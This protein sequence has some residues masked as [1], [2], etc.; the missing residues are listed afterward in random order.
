[1]PIEHAIRLGA[2]TLSDLEE[3][4]GLQNAMG[5]F[6]WFYLGSEFCE[7]LLDETLCGDIANLQKKGKKVCLSTP[8]LSEKGAARLK[9]I[10][11]VLSA[12][13]KSGKV[14][15]SRLELSVN[16]FAAIELARTAKLPVKISAG[17]IF[18]ENAFTQSKTYLYVLSRQ[19]LRFLSALGIKRYNISAAGRKPRSNFHN[20]MYSLGT[21]DFKISLYYPYLN[22]TTA[23]ACLAG[24]PD[25]APHQSISG[26]NC[27][28]EC[29]SGAFEVAHPWIKETLIIRG[30]T[31]FIK[32]P[33]KFYS[34][35]KELTK[36]R[37][38]RLVYC[39]FP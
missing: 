35:E 7:N 18:Y 39:P 6:N 24:M 37:I 9:K 21:P 4:G 5:R 11:S 29:R 23:R 38:D 16:D 19:S 20:K 3:T 27:R 28:R 36:L 34:S 10:F 25:I 14:D 13:E 33:N 17:R 26:V 8:F 1:M 2:M 31:V 15:F 22:L 12:L 32:F 30:N